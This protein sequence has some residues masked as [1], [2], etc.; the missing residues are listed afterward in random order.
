MDKDIFDKIDYKLVEIMEMIEQQK[1]FPML[2]KHITEYV[3][4]DEERI[5]LCSLYL[6][7]S[8]DARIGLENG[9]SGTQV[10][11]YIDKKVGIT[12]NGEQYIALNVL[13]KDNRKFNF[14]SKS[15]EVID[16]LSQTN[17][18]KFQD[19]KLHF[20]FNREFNKEKKI[21]YWTCEIIGVG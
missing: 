9:D 6:E 18:T 19:V 21:S 2:F 4:D 8:T 17:F 5:K 3:G 20:D 16:K 13:S 1:D 10:F 11:S 7:I 14:I 12:Q 15:P